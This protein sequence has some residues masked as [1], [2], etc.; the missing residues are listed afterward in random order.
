MS[1]PLGA[2]LWVVVSVLSDIPAQNQKVEK[3]KKKRKKTFSS[4]N[5]YCFG[6]RKVG[7]KEKLWF[8][9][10]CWDEIALFEKKIKGYKG[11]GKED[12]WNKPQDFRSF[13]KNTKK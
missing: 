9:H 13:K 10:F 5:N 11:L 12:L 8:I 3:E 2:V 4:P 6:E 1:S 7:N